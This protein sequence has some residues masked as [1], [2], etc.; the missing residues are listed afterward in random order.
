[1]PVFVL[2]WVL[3]Q[4]LEVGVDVRKGRRGVEVS[5]LE[6]GKKVRVRFD[7]ESFEDGDFLVGESASLLLG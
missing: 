4:E 3:K 7:D 1:M 6:D 5:E 2:R